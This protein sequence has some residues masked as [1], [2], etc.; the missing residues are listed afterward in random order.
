MTILAEPKICPSQEPSWK[1]M[2]EDL[3]PAQGAW[4][5]KE[6]LVL[7]EH[8]GRLVEYT[9]GVLEFLPMPTFEHQMILMYLSFEFF[10]FLRARG[11]VSVIAPLQLRV[12]E[13]KFREPDLM[14]MFSR[15]DP[16]LENEFWQGADLV[17]EVVSKDKPERDLID[18]R[19]DYAEG[20]IPEYWI[21]NPLT[22][23]ITVLRLNGKVYEEAGVYPRG[24]SA[25]SVLM[26]EFSV[27]VDAVFDAAK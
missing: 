3:L 20:N 15:K 25:K 7:T 26:P 27:S 13:G 10:Q 12:R 16:R 24:K 18:K 8:C 1:D 19:G 11:G 5:E 21:V 9:D 23:L 6:Y 22:Q 2:L 4:S 17:L 14:A